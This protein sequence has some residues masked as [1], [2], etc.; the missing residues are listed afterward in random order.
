MDSIVNIPMYL[1][2]L[3]GSNSPVFPA[4]ISNFGTKGSHDIRS[5]S[6]KLLIRWLKHLV[7]RKELPSCNDFLSHDMCIDE[8]LHIS[9]YCDIPV[10]EELFSKIKVAIESLPEDF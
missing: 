6:F 2:E 9:T 8:W 10:F 1:R 7:M 5:E 3:F 4:T